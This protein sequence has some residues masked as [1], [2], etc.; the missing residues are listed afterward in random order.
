MSLSASADAEKILFAA[1]QRMADG[2]VSD[3]LD[4]LTELTA[5]NPDF[6]KGFLSLANI[7]AFHFNDFKSAE[8]NFKKAIALTPDY[9]ASYLGY[10]ELLLQQERFTEALAMLNKA[11]EI[12]GVKKDK[13]YFLFGTMYELQS[14]FDD[15]LSF[16]KKGIVATLSNDLLLSCEKAI[17]RCEI[18]KKY[19]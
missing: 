12:Q 4:M 17:Q 15:A 5:V 11:I 13:T 18:K 3:A 1:S 8:Q 19:I 10:T 6:G 7:Y 2:N 16:Y 9:A 14:R